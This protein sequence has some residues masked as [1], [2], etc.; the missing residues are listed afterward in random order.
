MTTVWSGTNTLRP[1]AYVTASLLCIFLFFFP[2][3]FQTKTMQ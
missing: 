3:P 2:Q 1:D